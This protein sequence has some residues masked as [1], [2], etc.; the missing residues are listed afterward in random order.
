MINVGEEWPHY[1]NKDMFKGMAVHGL[2]IQPS[3]M[4]DDGE[5]RAR[6]GT[7]KAN[8]YTNDESKVTCGRCRRK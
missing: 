2:Y 3:F 7:V 1:I 8:L 5:A 6:C 4:E